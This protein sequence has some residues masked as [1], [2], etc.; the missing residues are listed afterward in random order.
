M[1]IRSTR[2]NIKSVLLISSVF[3]FVFLALLVNAVISVEA[4][5]TGG[6]PKEIERTKEDGVNTLYDKSSD[7]SDA[8]PGSYQPYQPANQN[9]NPPTT[10]KKE[11][12]GCFKFKSSNKKTTPCPAN[13]SPK[14]KETECNC[15]I[16]EGRAKPARDPQTGKR[17]YTGWWHSSGNPQFTTNVCGDADCE[18]ACQKAISSNNAASKKADKCEEPVGETPTCTC[19]PNNGGSGGSGNGSSNGGGP[20]S[21]ST[22]GTAPGGS[23]GPASSPLG[24]PGGPGGAPSPSTPG[25]VP[26]T[27]PGGSPTGTGAP[28]SPGSH[29]PD[30]PGG[31][32]PM[33]AGQ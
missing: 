12:G 27:G 24:I 18:A 10:E 14:I 3:S 6:P 7:V 2:F 32:G 21:S 8:F 1:K 17:G 15:F 19:T 30:A 4:Q 29:V 9:A 22:G 26:P 31:A 33:S 25:G 13:S 28:A 5:A 16:Y 20:V 11:A 23:F